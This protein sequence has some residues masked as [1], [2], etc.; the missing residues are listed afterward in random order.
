MQ[1]NILQLY[2]IGLMIFFTFLNLSTF[3]YE[4]SKPLETTSQ[5]LYIALIN[6]YGNTKL[7]ASHYT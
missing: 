4:L 5:R 6:I 2:L 1:L 3:L 7:N